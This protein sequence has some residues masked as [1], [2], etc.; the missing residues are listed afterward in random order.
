MKKK[1]I[2]SVAALIIAAIVSVTVMS[3]KKDNEKNNDTESLVKSHELSDMDKK[4]IA[5]GEKLKTASQE[6]AKKPCPWL[7]P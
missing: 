6:R 4:M 2:L 5:F 7:K 3:C 1:N